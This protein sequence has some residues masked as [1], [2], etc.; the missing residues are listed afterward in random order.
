MLSQVRYKLESWINNALGRMMGLG[1]LVVKLS[2][3]MNNK[4]FLNCVNF[5][6]YIIYFSI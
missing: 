4:L 6:L 5:I 3:K 1:Y 2:Y